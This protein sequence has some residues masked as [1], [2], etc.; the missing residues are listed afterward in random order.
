MT[1]ATVQPLLTFPQFIGAVLVSFFVS[2]A[3]V[4]FLDS[5]RDR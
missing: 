5:R 1:A 2:F 3:V 4:A